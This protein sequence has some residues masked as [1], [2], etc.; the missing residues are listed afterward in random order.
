MGMTRIGLLRHWI[1]HQR[2]DLSLRDIRVMRQVWLL[3][4]C[5]RESLAIID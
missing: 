4:R 2:Q 3:E 1:H 5:R